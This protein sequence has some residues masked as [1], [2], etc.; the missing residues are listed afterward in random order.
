MNSDALALIE[1]LRYQLQENSEQYDS[2]KL[3]EIARKLSVALETP[4][5]TIWRISGLHLT[6]N[7]CRIATKLNLFNIL[8][9][10]HG[11]RSG[12][13]LV[14]ETKV[15]HD[16]LIRL[17]RYLAANDII[18][19][20]GEDLWTANSITKTLAIP[21]MEARFNFMSD[22]AGPAGSALPAFLE[23][24]GYRNPID[25]K[26]CAFQSAFD[27][28]DEFFGWLVKHPEQHHNFNSSM[29]GRIEGQ[30]NWLDF[31]P[32]EDR[33]VQGFQTK[34]DAVSIVDIGGGFGYVLETVLDRYPG[35][36]GRC[37]LQDLP[38][39]IKQIKSPRTGAR[40]YHLKNILHDWPDHQ[41]KIIL[42]Q[43]I[44]AMEKGYSKIIIHDIVLPNQGVNMN[45]VQK[46][47]TVSFSLLDPSK[48][49]VEMAR[50][51]VEFLQMM[52][53]F[54]ATERTEKQWRKLLGS[55]GLT[56]EKIWRD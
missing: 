50:V 12:D 10:S 49:S 28:T 27:T 11:P 56:I 8:V 19:E 31:F 6:T 30:A 34:N 13:E 1:D 51:K 35:L 40:A 36:K 25:S 52:V 2:E 15:E 43:I 39:T 42:E 53:F 48:V 26:K 55:V 41:C 9:E 33:I 14:Q 45:S 46:D 24:T 22:T 16:L 5:D 32:L 54:A 18:G 47:L 23:K 38:G 4:R 21:A 44:P 3:R 20:A 37:V 17:L 7:I 29:K